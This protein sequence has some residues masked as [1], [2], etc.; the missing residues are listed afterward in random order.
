[1]MVAA[2]TLATASTNDKQVVRI[3]TSLPV[4]SGPD[5]LIRKIAERLEPVWGKTVI[6]DNRPGGNGLVALRAYQADT[7][8]NTLFAGDSSNFTTLPLL[9]KQSTLLQ[10]IEPLVPIT[11]AEMMLF[12]GPKIQ[13][14][15]ELVSAI[16]QPHS[17]GSWGVGSPAHFNGLIYLDLLGNR[18]TS[19][20]VPY[21][22]YG[23]WFTDTSNQN[24]LFGFAT[25]GSAGNLEQS[26]RLKFFAF[27]GKTRH[28][29]WPHV[30]TVQ[31]LTSQNVEFIK[32]WVAFVIKDNVPS[33]TKKKY[34]KDIKQIID[35][36]EYKKIMASLNYDHWDITPDE[37]KKFVKD[38]SATYQKII[39]KYNIQ[40]D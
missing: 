31:E 18:Q 7:D 35:S 13:S 20:H 23:V 39:T 32:P 16:K 29:K 37:F 19:V 26:K 21:K 38:Q 24:L 36:D 25:T 8:P 27:T 14:Y 11:L 2:T 33:D 40:L 4:G 15:G 34:A 5:G 3:I 6:V 9:L 22:D 10:N 28:P 1:M 17:Y 30:P 12:T